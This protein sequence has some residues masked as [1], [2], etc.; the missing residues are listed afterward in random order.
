MRLSFEAQSVIGLR[1]FRMAT[2]GVPAGLE[3]MHVTFADI[4]RIL[5]LSAASGQPQEAA[6]K[7][8]LHEAAMSSS[9]AQPNELPPDPD[10]SPSQPA[11]DR[12]H[13]FGP[14]QRQR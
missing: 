13:P 7:R 11:A 2:G 12:D 3:A 1:L 5:M 9:P 14:H 10:G 4:Q 6:P 8:I